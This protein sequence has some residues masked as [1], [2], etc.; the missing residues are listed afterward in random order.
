MAATPTTIHHPPST[1]PKSWEILLH[2]E[3]Q[4]RLNSPSTGNP[5]TQPQFAD[6]K[7]HFPRVFQVSPLPRP[8][9]WPPLPPPHGNSKNDECS[10]VEL[11][12]RNS[13]K[14]WCN[15]GGRWIS[16]PKKKQHGLNLNLKIHL[17][18]CLCFP[19]KNYRKT[20]ETNLHDLGVQ[21]NYSSSGGV[22]RCFIL[23]T[24]S[25][26]KNIT[27][28]WLCTSTSSCENT[29]VSAFRPFAPCC[30]IQLQALEW[31]KRKNEKSFKKKSYCQ[32]SNTSI[33]KGGGPN[34]PKPPGA[35][36]IIN[37]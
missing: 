20:K 12:G 10:Q 8:S 36:P 23:G 14:I 31:K 26:P 7:L 15:L 32:V 6:K 33:H 30:R 29:T 37:H 5:K 9:S 22:C 27:G 11:G 35:K 24:F 19:E 4:L 17:Y 3:N 16:P 2:L 13:G 28:F 25:F 18:I 21:N 34:Q 1:N